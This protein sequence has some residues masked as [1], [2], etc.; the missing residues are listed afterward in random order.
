MKLKEIL[1]HVP[2]K[3]VSNF[4][5]YEISG[6]TYDSRKVKENYIFVA[7][8]GTK[9]DGHNFIK[10]AID[11]GAKVIFVER[12][13]LLP[14][15]ITQVVVE[16]TRETLALISSIFYGNPSDKLKVIGITG[17][18]GKTTTSYLLKSILTE[19]GKKCGLIG[20][21]M[22]EIGERKIS[23]I[24]TTPESLDIEELLSQ[25]V[26]MGTTHAIMEVSSHGLDQGRVKFINF[27]AGIMTNISSH[28]HLDYHKSFKNYLKA[29]LSFFG[30]YLAESKKKKKIGIVNRDDPYSKYFINELKRNNIEFITYGRDKKSDVKLI[31]FKISEKGNYLKVES[32]GK[33]Y[34]FST[35]ITGRGNIYNAVA[36]ISYAFFE[37]IPVEIIKKGLEN[38]KSVPGRFE[39]IDE[40]QP[41]SVIVDYAHTSHS[42]ENLLLSV[43]DLNPK[44]IIL[45]FGCGGDRDR[46]KRPVMGKIAV[47][48]ADIVIITSDNPRSEDPMDII[49]DI[50]KGIGWLR[51]KKCKIIPDRKEAI[52]EGIFLAE[53]GD[54]VVIAGKGHETYQIL[55]D[56][57][58]PFDD[59]EEARKFIRERYGRG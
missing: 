57:V 7:I 31:D 8:K 49:R 42:L 9:L 4:K 46:S 36:S 40:G 43:R 15:D 38:I 35:P 3:K 37:G 30:R 59:R 34:E 41:F 45:I 24:N 54:F 55:K 53:E 33:I 17:T 20:T 19:S 29:K 2:D 44:R 22:Y 51:R 56:T 16:N 26:E 47:K 25:M 10:D 21:V 5:N 50:E 11:R 6:I 48:M 39:F 1:K 18:N 14:H 27:D 52:K 58:I 23:S 28:E 13:L 32:G 12:E